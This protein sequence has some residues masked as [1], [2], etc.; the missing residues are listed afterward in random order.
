MY[1]SKPRPKF[2]ERIRLEFPKLSR[3]QTDELEAYITQKKF[4]KQKHSAVLREW[5]KE[6]AALK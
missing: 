2:T 1:Q 3:D 5:A 4:H 6:K